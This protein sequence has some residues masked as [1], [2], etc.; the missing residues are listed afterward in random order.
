MV[1]LAVEATLELEWLQLFRSANV[2][3]HRLPAV[4]HCAHSLNPLRALVSRLRKK[5]SEHEKALK[6]FK[7]LACK[8][9]LVD[10]IRT[11]CGEFADKSLVAPQTA[12]G[13]HSEFSP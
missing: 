5:L 6:E 8:N 13:C 12:R 4:A 3:S 7:C 2:I 10:P 1:T 11:P 9:V